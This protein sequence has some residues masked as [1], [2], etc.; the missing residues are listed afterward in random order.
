MFRWLFPFGNLIA[1]NSAK[2]HPT[3]KQTHRRQLK[4]LTNSDLKGHLS[5]PLF[6]H[7]YYTNISAQSGRKYEFFIVVFFLAKR[8]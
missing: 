1:A 5:E 6:C 3:C 7:I 8:R 4:A 2:Y